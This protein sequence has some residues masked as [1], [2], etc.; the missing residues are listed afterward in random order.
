MNQLVRLMNAA[1][2]RLDIM[3]PGYFPNAKHNHYRDFGYPEEL[4]FKQ[5]Y[6][7]YLRNGIARAGVNKTVLKTWQDA[8]FLLEKERD[9][10]EAG[11]SDE[12]KLEKDIR[13]R[14]SDLRLWARLAD[15]DRMS[16]VGGYAGV[17]L[18]FRDGRRWSDPVNR[19]PGG[20]NGIAKIIPVWKG[21]LAPSDWDT[22]PTSE[23]YGDP[24][25]YQFKESGVGEDK[26]NFRHFHVHPDRVLIWSADE[27][28]HERS[29]LEPGY[30]DLI[31]LEKVKGSGGEGFWKNAKSAPVLEI[32]KEARIEEMA[33]AM[34]VSATEVVDKMNDQVADWQ[35][36]FDQL[37]MLQGMQAKTLGIVLPSPEHFFS[38]ALQSFAASI[39]MPVKILVGMQT[40]ERASQ[41]DASEWAQTN[42]S[43]RANQTIPNIMAL[44]NR[45]ERFGILPER[46]WHLDWSDL[47]EASMG[48][49]IDRADKMADVN[50]KMKDSGEFVFTPE[51]IRASV[52]YEPLSDAEKFRDELTDDEKNAAL[53]AQAPKAGNE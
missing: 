1:T 15:A 43:R 8:P 37:L 52:G 12:T 44:V 19:V 40:G 20:L 4:T 50:Q 25:M 2:R 16:L 30:N 24:V 6:D 14:S 18:S 46:D 41:E 28:V 23:A 17:L 45:L 51:E 38:I 31:D 36:G 27:T 49:K 48:E 22:D 34:G 9:G 10:S 13:E 29:L 26:R 7:M 32:D 53:P 42:M 11:K 39:N 35:K 3:F 21:Q 5:L 47:T 33:R